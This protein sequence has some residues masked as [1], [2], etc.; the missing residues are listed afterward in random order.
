MGRDDRS[1][2]HDVFLILRRQNGG[3]EKKH[4]AYEGQHGTTPC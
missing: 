4:G 2:G 1:K 3:R